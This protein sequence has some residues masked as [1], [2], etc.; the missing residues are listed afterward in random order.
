MIKHVTTNAELYE[1][2]KAPKVLVDF[3]ATWCGPCNRLTPIIEKVSE[4]HPELSVIKIDVDEVP[5]V[6]QKYEVRS[7]P[8]LL[9]VEEGKIIDQTLGYM[10]EE[11]L[12]SFVH[13]G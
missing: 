6:A 8:T 7:I 12:L 9:Y 10:P 13:L 3:Y 5:E 4:E 11:A 2:M 1:A